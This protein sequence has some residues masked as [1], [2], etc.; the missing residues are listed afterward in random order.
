MTGRDTGVARRFAAVAAFAVALPLAGCGDD[1]T[2]LVGVMV[3]GPAPQVEATIVA[4]ATAP[5]GGGLP[6]EIVLRNRTGTTVTVPI[7]GTAQQMFFNAEVLTPQGQVVFRSLDPLTPIPSTTVPITLAPG[8]EFRLA[9]AWD[10]RDPAT[11]QFVTAGSYH[12][13]ATV[14]STPSN[15]VAPQVSVTVTP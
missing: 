8:G 3:A 14:F 12:V 13:R 2:G 15:L 7:V 6:I 11:G 10:M 5:I 4:P 1:E 9:T